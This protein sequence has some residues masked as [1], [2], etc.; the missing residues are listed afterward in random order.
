MGGFRER[1]ELWVIMDAAKRE[2]EALGARV[3]TVVTDVSDPESVAA[4]GRAVE[5]AFGKLQVLFEG[6][7]AVRV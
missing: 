2:V 3:T 4:A 5:Q 6:G 7:F 1:V